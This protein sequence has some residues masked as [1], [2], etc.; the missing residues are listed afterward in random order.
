MIATTPVRAD[1]ELRVLF[2]EFRRRTY[3]HVRRYFRAE[4]GAMQPGNKGVTIA[5][6]LR[7]LRLRE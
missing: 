4:S 3:L 5:P 6:D 1:E 7:P 2:D